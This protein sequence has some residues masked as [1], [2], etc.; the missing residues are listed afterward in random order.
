MLTQE[1]SKTVTP[2]A[3]VEFPF[4]LSRKPLSKGCAN[5]TE[6]FE[7]LENVIKMRHYSPKTFKVIL[8]QLEKIIDL[9]EQ[10][11]LFGFCGVFST[12]A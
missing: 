2:E 4:P 7:P 6:V 3:S 1:D 11:C 9:H 5:W 10:E 8:R 12:V